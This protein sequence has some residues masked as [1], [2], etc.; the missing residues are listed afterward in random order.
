MDIFRLRTS[1]SENANKSSPPIVVDSPPIVITPNLSKKRDEEEKWTSV[2][3]KK[4][5]KT[6]KVK[7]NHCFIF[8]RLHLIH[9]NAQTSS[10]ANAQISPPKPTIPGAVYSQKEG[11]LTFR[12]KKI[13][14][15]VSVFIADK[16]AA[17][18]KAAD[19]EMNAN[20]SAAKISPVLQM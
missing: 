6:N 19:Q 8:K 3:S 20:K 11:K 9:Q 10:G 17:A 4:T 12:S 2:S 7:K 18:R 5:S 16:L 14:L 1:E 15:R 13:H